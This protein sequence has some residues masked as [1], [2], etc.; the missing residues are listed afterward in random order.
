VKQ[1]AS[2]DPAVE[3]ERFQGSTISVILASSHPSG[4]KGL[5]AE[6]NS[7]SAT[8][9]ADKKFAARE[10]INSPSRPKI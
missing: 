4:K 1:K 8:A 9:E 6:K 7:K 2:Q 5:R 10:F 3:V